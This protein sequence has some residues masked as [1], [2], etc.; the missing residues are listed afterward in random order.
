MASHK[1]NTTTAG[2]G[3][4]SF[5]SKK[6]RKITL[7]MILASTSLTR[8]SKETN[9][10]YLA[11]VTHLHLQGKRIKAIEGLELCTNLKVSLIES[12]V[13]FKTMTISLF[14]D[15][16][17]TYMKIKLSPYRTWISRPFYNTYICKT[18]K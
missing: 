7:D 14:V 18:T 1:G 12:R 15:R 11:R 4:G 3:G 16:C 2:G 10:T 13:T 17:C 8:S 5:T 9:E 6:Y